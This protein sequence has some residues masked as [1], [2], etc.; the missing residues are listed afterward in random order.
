MGELGALGLELL[1]GAGHDR[2]DDQVLAV[3]AELGGQDVLGQRA[4]HLLGAAAGG[5]IGQQVG[6][7]LLGEFHP[8]GAAACEL[9]EVFAFG[10]AG[11]ELVGFLDD[12]EVGGEAGVVDGVEAH[13]LEG[14]DDAAGHGG[15]VGHAEGLADGDADG[16]GDL[17]D[18]GLGGVGQ[19][20]PDGFEFGGGGEGAG[21]ADAGALAAVDALDLAHG[22]VEG[23]EDG[24]LVAAVGEVNRADALNLVA[25]ADAVAAEHALVGV[26]DDAG[27]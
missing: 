20:V 1:G 15:V 16:G 17:N 25:E 22:L 18:D 13:A 19:G 6:E 10:L 8:A 14:G 4:E 12:G 7:V 27:A 3:D 9:G 11:E 2:D 21:G 24:R 26:A 5:E 23:G